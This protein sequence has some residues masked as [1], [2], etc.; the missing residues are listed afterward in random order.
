MKGLRK[1][2]VKVKLTKDKGKVEKVKVKKRDE[3]MEKAEIKC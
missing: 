2:R 3:F 1:G